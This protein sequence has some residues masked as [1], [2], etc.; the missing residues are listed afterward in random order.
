VL[1]RSRRMWSGGL[2]RLALLEGQ[3]G[4]AGADRP[5]A[6]ATPGLVSLSTCTTLSSLYSRLQNALRRLFLSM[7]SFLNPYL[8]LASQSVAAR[9]PCGPPEKRSM[10]EL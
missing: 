3:A 8:P 1:G 7:T 5:V 10:E 4:L 2:I 6:T 9:V